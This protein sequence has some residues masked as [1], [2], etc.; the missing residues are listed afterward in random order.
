MKNLLIILSLTASINLTSCSSKKSSNEQ[1]P[2]EASTPSETKKEEAVIIQKQ[3]EPDTLKG[4]LKAEAIGK[5]G[6]T[7]IKV[8]YHS[9]AVRGRIVWGGLVPFDK[10]W[11][12]GAHMA[13]SIE[14]NNDLVIDGKTIPTGKYAFFTI[15]GKDEWTIII[16][17]N[18]QQHLTDKYDAKE[19]VVRVK[20]KP[21]TEEPHQERLRYEIEADS[22]IQGEIVVYWEKL[23]ISLPVSLKKLFV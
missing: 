3:S 21:E 14:F 13:T 19:D 9:P 22:K 6:D 4:S 23:E 12:A 5:I 18:W 2:K 15:P 17:K 10:V 8:S 1:K 16:N 7:E 20:V 11:V